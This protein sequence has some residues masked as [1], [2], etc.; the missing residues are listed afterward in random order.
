MTRPV[1][2]LVDD[3]AGV[4]F[5]LG[6]VLSEADVEVIEAENGVDALEKMRDRRADL[7]ITD[8]KMPKMDGMALLA[9]IRKQ[10][11]SLKVVMITAHG[12]ESAAVEAMKL[13][14]YDYFPKP[15]D[16]DAVASVVK[17]ATE[18][19]R[20]LSENRRLKA[21]LV[22]AR[23]M[24]FRSE[25][26]MRVAELVERIAPKDV[27]VLIAGKSGTGKE[28]VARAIVEAS[29]RAD[30]PF[31]TFNCAA[32]AK[33]LAEAELFGHKEGAFTGATSARSGLFRQADGGTIFLDEIAE[34]DLEVQGKLL[35][36]IQ[37][38]EVRPVGEDRA[39]KVDVRIISATHRELTQE[40]EA[41]RF[42]ED[43]FYRLNVVRIDLPPLSERPEDL[44][45][46][47]DHF[48]AKYAERFGIENPQ[49]TPSARRRLLSRTYPGNVRE[50]ENT[51]ERML[52]LATGST[53]D[54]LSGEEVGVTEPLG[55]KE[56]VDAYERGLILAELKRAGWNRSEAARRLK[57]GRVTLLDKLKKHNVSEE[58]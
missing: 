58:E 29:I 43:L 26:M 11:P 33:G 28:L 50:L 15:F 18:A 37:E 19:V 12:S 5:T 53:I 21:E 8:L 39:V 42:R 40:V 10:D 16:V 36:V 14:A 52:A 3:D 23:K 24:I 1:V 55:L 17:R 51:V 48:V 54:D 41:G 57:I 4:R 27:T 13:G 30:R 20:L 38:G 7:V 9:E 2:L 47:I 35:R 31:V 25:R 45:P 46:L 56:R 32:I 49:L 34:L 22:L 44:E 6:E